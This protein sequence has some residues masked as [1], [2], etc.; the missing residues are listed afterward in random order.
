MSTSKPRICSKGHKFYKSSDCPTCPVCEKQRKP[1][2]DFL[3]FIS[4]PAK[5]A[6]E[7]ESISTLL[8]LSKYSE[9]EILTLHGMGP[10]SI[11]KLKNALKEKGLSFRKK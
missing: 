4:S 6:L 11:P 7:R 10:G 3:S 5:R 1:D 9:K 8:K 2:T